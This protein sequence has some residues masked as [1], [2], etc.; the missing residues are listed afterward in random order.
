L[1]SSLK[2][3]LTDA[4]LLHRHGDEEIYDRFEVD[5]RAALSELLDELVL[6][7]LRITRRY[8][9]KFR[10]VGPLREI[11]ARNFVAARAEDEGR[12]ATGLAA[13]DVCH[14]PAGEFVIQDINMD[15]A[16]ELFL[17]TGY[18]LERIE[19]KQIAI[20]SRFSVL[21]DRGITE[22][23]IQELDELYEELPSEVRVMLRE[24]DTGTLL[25]PADVGV[26]LS[27][28]IPVVAACNYGSPSLL[29]I[30]QPELHIH[31]AV[32]V[33]LGD[34]FIA[35][36]SVDS[37]HQSKNDSPGFF[38]SENGLLLETHS[39]HLLLRLL[40]RIRE[41]HDGDLPPEYRPFYPNQLAVIYVE[42]TEQGTRFKT[43]RV[44]KS[45]DFIDPWPKGFFEERAE[46]LF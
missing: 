12:W 4:P 37:Y 8:M 6:G 27:Q 36:A 24:I 14:G 17:N 34:V 15:L 1:E 7:P 42:P 28:L 39:E 21:F 29:A 10:Y 11:P 40:R 33:A 18:A 26:G 38:V 19:T 3:D 31:P 5:R 44:S 35:Y 30:E 45:G 22:D 32:Q 13:W 41:T 25:A 9:S 43:L 23:D 46:E 16:D 2:I 20:P